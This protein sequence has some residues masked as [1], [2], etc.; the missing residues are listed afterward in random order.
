MRISEIY[1]KGLYGVYTYKIANLLSQNLLVLTG[2]NGMGKTTILNI[3]KNIAESNLWF[4]YKLDF[5]EIKVSF[6]D[7]LLLKMLSN[8]S[9]QAMFG[10]KELQDENINPEKLLTY[11]WYRDKKLLSSVTVG[12]HNF[13]KAFTVIY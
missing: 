8:N 5:E 13:Y 10:N 9:E 3:V 2:Y 11:A 6:E 4:F 12:R 1:I 7:G